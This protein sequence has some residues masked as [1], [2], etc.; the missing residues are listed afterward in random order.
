MFLINIIWAAFPPSAPKPNEVVRRSQSFLHTISV[1]LNL[2]TRKKG[3]RS[4]RAA[5][6]KVEHLSFSSIF[7]IQLINKKDKDSIFFL[8]IKFGIGH[9]P[10][11]SKVLLVFSKFNLTKTPIA[12]KADEYVKMPQ[13]SESTAQRNESL[14]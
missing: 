11:T 10:V 14:T 8:T 12:G 6:R 2:S 13:R 4:S 3:S 5:L 7:A 1:K 9:Y